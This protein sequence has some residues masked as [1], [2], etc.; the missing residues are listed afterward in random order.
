MSKAQTA[1]NKL[2]SS[3]LENV[4]FD[5]LKT[6]ALAMWYEDFVPDSSNF[7][8]N[9]S[10]VAG[11]VVDKLMRFNCVPK[12]TKLKL[13]EFVR[14]QKNFVQAPVNEMRELRGRDKLALSWGLGS[15]LKHYVKDLLPFQTRHYAH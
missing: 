14:Q 5:D 7:S 8:G 1:F 15:D 10:Q 2:V 12:E 6:V 9:D 11:Y 13:G 3:D 4:C